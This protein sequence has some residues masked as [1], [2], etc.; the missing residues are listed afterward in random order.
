METCKKE[1]D[2]Q[3]SPASPERSIHEK[4]KLILLK[5]FMTQLK[6]EP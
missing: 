3:M 2:T 6:A 1:N 5:Q 4:D